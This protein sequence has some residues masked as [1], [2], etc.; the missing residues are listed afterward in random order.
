MYQLLH[1][2]KVFMSYPKNQEDVCEFQCQIGLKAKIEMQAA[3]NNSTKR[4]CCLLSLTQ[5]KQHH[6]CGKTPKQKSPWSAKK[7]LF[8]TSNTQHELQNSE[9]FTFLC[10]Q[11]FYIIISFLSL[12]GKNGMVSQWECFNFSFFILPFSLQN[13][14]K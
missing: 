11:V 3:E 10:K 14:S 5:L 2:L 6:F 8:T 1:F 13:S 12:L 9:I 4:M 7:S